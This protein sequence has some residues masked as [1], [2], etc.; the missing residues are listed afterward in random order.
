MKFTNQG[1]A[2]KPDDG[3]RPMTKAERDLYEQT[4]KMK[5]DRSMSEHDFIRSIR[6]D[7]AKYAQADK[8]KKA[9]DEAERKAREEKAKNWN[10]S[11]RPNRFDQDSSSGIL[12]RKED[13]SD[14]GSR[15]ARNRVSI[16]PLSRSRSSL[17]RTGIH[18][19]KALK[20]TSTILNTIET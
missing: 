8:E 3:S 5:K 1:Q 18:K 4:L 15:T 12:S 16:G 11:T 20:N 10:P 2:D 17:P 19:A 9:Q 7:A 14:T 13:S 6:V